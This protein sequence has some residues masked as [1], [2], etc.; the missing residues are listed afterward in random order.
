MTEVLFI[1]ITVTGA[2]EVTRELAD[3]YLRGWRVISHTES[4]DVYSFVLERKPEMRQPYRA[5]YQ[6]RSQAEGM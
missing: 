4:E 3:W 1:K 6:T 5:T 2:E